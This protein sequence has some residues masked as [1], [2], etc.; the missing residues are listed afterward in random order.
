MLQTFK[1]HWP[2]Y[3][4]EAAGLGFFMTC[5]SLFT[6][7]LEYPH[8]PVHGAVKEP[9]ARLVVL[10]ILMGCVIA[11]V[12][13]SPWGKKSGAHI[14]PA[15]TLAFWR[16]GKITTWDAVFYI[17]FQFLG[18]LLAVQIMGLILGAAYRHPAIKH[19]VTIPGPSGPL[20]AFLAE[21]VISF[22]LMLV[23]LLVINSKK[24]EKL[25]GLFAGILI[26]LYLI[27]ES[28]YS[29]MSLNP[30]RTFASAFGARE[31]TG[32]WIYF[33]APCLAMLLAGEAFKR[34]VGGHVEV[35]AV[36]MEEPEEAAAPHPV[37]ASLGAQ[38]LEENP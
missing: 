14:N 28:P 32:L 10:G 36:P 4:A 19:V 33:A 21:F 25:A 27:L 26:A 31:W 2:H 7:L 3:L 15:V 34:I 20:K 6:T 16:I 23:L 11:A 12:V 13:Y 30:A 1:N 18:G 38:P 35:A 22:I 17:L 29:G 9:F 37:A 24:T 5:A 8:S